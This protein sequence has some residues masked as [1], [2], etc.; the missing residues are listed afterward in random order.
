M[1][2]SPPL[3]GL[4]KCLFNHPQELLP[5]IWAK[6]PLLGRTRV[7]PP[8]PSD[9]SICH[10]RIRRSPAVRHACTRQRSTLFGRKLLSLSSRTAGHGSR[11]R[12]QKGPWPSSRS[13][14]WTFPAAAI[15]SAIGLVGWSRPRESSCSAAQAVIR[16]HSHAPQRPQRTTEEP[17]AISRTR[18]RPSQAYRANISDQMAQS[19]TTQIDGC[20]YL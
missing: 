3:S 12:G 19:W 6:A 2:R 15:Y 16:A 10:L 9:W 8:Y 4:R 17:V 5:C 1:L 7:R 20:R 13:R 18:T 14:R 11:R